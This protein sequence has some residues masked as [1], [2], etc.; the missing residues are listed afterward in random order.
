MTHRTDLLSLILGL[1]TVAIGSAGL[2]VSASDVDVANVDLRFLGPVVLGLLG[3][4]ML[5]IALQARGRRGSPAAQPETTAQPE[6]GSA[7]SDAER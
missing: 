5:A 6:S 7:G 2:A 3:V 4:L 1:I